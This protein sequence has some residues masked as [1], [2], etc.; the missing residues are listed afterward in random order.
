MNWKNDLTENLIWN[1]GLSQSIRLQN[2]GNLFFPSPSANTRKCWWSSCAS[3][4]YCLWMI[5]WSLS[6][7]SSTR[8]LPAQASTVPYVAGVSNLNALLRAENEEEAQPAKRKTFKDYAPGFVHMDV[9]YLPQ[10]ADES[11][12]TYLFVAIDRATRW[13]YLAKSPDSSRL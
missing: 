3:C 2:W 9:K 11:R 10:M 12:R 13:V 5:C 6:E 1:H 8:R 7:N 4:C